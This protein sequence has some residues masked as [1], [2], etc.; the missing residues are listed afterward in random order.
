MNFIKNV[1]KVIRINKKGTFGD[2]FK[3][4]LIGAGFMILY[5]IYLF[6]AKWLESKGL[7]GILK[8]K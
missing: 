5:M 2:W 4:S 6:I 3:L 8:P 7:G 1:G